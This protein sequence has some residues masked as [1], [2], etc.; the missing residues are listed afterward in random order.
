MTDSPFN[1]LCVDKDGQSR[2]FLVTVAVYEDLSPKKSD[3]SFRSL[4]WDFEVHLRDPRHVATDGMFTATAWELDPHTVVS[5]ELH[6]SRDHYT[7][8]GIPEAVINL[9]RRASGR[10]VLSSTWSAVHQV[11]DPDT[12]TEPGHAVWRRFERNGLATE[13]PGENRFRYVETGPLS[14]TASENND[15][16]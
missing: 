1:L 2:T 5:K 10:T 4:H 16:E 6:A 14:V 8:K 3:P 9:L 11:F 12:Q 15:A 7:G 13:Q